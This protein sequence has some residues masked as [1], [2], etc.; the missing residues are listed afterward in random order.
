M[1]YREELGTAAGDLWLPASEVELEKWSVVACDQYT[2]QPDYWNQVEELVGDAPSTL[3]M[4]FP[5]IYLGNNG[6]EERVANIQKAMEQYTADGI[7][8]PAVQEGFI[9]VE[10]TVPTGKRLGLMMLADLEAYDFSVGSTSL[11]RATE[12]TIIERIPPRVAVRQGATLELPHIMLLIDDQKET[13]IEPLYHSRETLRPL[14]DLELMQQ[15]GHLR[16][17]AVEGEAV[18]QV[19]A[20]LSDRKAECG[21]L[22]YAVGDGNHSLA[23]ARQCWLNIRETLTQEERETHPARF[24]MV[25]LV[26]LYSEALVFEP[27]HRNVFHVDNNQLLKGFLAY[28]GEIDKTAK[29]VSDDSWDVQWIAGTKK[30]SLKFDNLGDSLPVAILQN[31]LDQYL[32]EHAEASIDYIHGADVVEQLCE[33]ESDTAGMLL[34]GMDKTSLFPFVRSEGSLPRK[35]FSMGEAYEKRYYMECRKISR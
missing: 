1:K 6:K 30:M 10:R 23:T 7:V 13:V 9:L 16:G 4:I 28:T 18:E 19:F 27:I 33:K 32:K 5:E 17:W 11:I 15:G 2:S 22:L 8:A 26:N 24:A 3:R 34:K 21:G 12:G 20:A 25:E 29:E 35:T 31:Y 14:Y